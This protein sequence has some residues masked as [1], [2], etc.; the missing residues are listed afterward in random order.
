MDD[1][2]KDEAVLFRGKRVCDAL[3]EDFDWDFEV[4]KVVCSGGGLTAQVRGGV[5]SSIG[6]IEVYN[7]SFDRVVR[8]NDARGAS[9]S[10]SPSVCGFMTIAES[11]GRDTSRSPET[12]CMVES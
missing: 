9:Y 4:G 10:S 11:E 1:L 12:D 3:D 8:D 7:L 6:D 2:V 5:L